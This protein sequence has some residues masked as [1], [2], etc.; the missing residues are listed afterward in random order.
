VLPTDIKT[1]PVT[2]R[3]ASSDFPYSVVPKS[4]SFNVV[5]T[6]Y[7]TAFTINTVVTPLDFTYTLSQGA[8]LKGAFTPTPVSV[9]NHPVTY[10]LTHNQD[11]TF[12]DNNLSVFN[13]ATK[14]FT[15]SFTDANLI[16]TVQQYILTATTVT[17]LSGTL[18]ATKI[19]NITI[20]PNCVTN[21]IV[22]KT[23]NNMAV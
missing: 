2:I 22:D 4:F 6:C 20:W 1:H 9:C 21:A 19:I 7:V 8:L 16:N 12:V 18:T 23:I 11:G 13:T 15:F 17:T 5:V 3:I 10:S 14:F